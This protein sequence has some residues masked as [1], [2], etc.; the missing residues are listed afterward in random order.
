MR[1]DQN[2][3]EQSQKK[4]FDKYVQSGQWK[5]DEQNISIF[6]ELIRGEQEKGFRW[7]GDCSKVLDYGY[8]V[9]N[10]ISEFN[11]I[12]PSESRIFY[13]VDISSASIEVCKSRFVGAF[14]CISNN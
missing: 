1:V 5:I 8:G 6:T 14:S 4:F 12:S 10:L 9:G 7:L 11:N 13:G 3:T 2:Q